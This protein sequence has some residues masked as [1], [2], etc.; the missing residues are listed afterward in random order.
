[1][2]DIIK[3]LKKSLKTKLSK[4]LE[5]DKLKQ[6]VRKSESDLYLLGSLLD[7]Y[8]ARLSETEVKTD[9]LHTTLSN[10][11]S[12]G[13]DITTNHHGEKSWAV[14]C[15]EGKYNVV[16]FIDLSNKEAD[17]VFRFLKNFEGS[18]YVNDTPMGYLP[19]DMFIGWNG[20]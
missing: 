16:K 19:K 15:V 11:V 12:F 7:K 17:D 2:S 1:M 9:S 4:Y 10:V 5:I 3:K 18:R 8:S 20:K 6:G 13:S 14:V